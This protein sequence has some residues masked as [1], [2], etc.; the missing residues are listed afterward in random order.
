MFSRIWWTRKIHKEQ[1]SL[2]F[3]DRKIS[4]VWIHCEMWMATWWKTVLFT[5]GLIDSCW[6]WCSVWAQLLDRKQQRLVLVTFGVEEFHSSPPE[7]IQTITPTIITEETSKIWVNVWNLIVGWLCWVLKRYPTFCTHSMMVRD[8]SGRVKG[9]DSD[10]S[11]SSTSKLMS[12]LPS[13]LDHGRFDACSLLS[14]S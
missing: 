4:M 5:S 6:W 11:I 8:W 2:S 7:S 13:L 1:S 12:V 9:R 10:I 3:S 14:A